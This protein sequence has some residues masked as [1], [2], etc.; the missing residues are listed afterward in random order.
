MSI[1]WDVVL[2]ICVEVFRRLLIAL[3]VFF[4]LIIGLQSVQMTFGELVCGVCLL[5]LLL[6][7]LMLHF[8][9]P[10]ESY[11]SPPSQD[12]VEHLLQFKSDWQHEYDENASVSMGKFISVGPCP[13]GL[14]EKVSAT[15]TSQL[16]RLVA[17]KKQGYWL[18]SSK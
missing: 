7:S 18:S 2:S 16:E 15:T 5:F 14:D 12:D 13:D 3:V 6:V 10:S 9:C 1:R 11:V 17:I 4:V 8:D